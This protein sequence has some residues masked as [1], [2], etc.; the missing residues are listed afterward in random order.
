MCGIAGSL[1]RRGPASD[2]T[3]RRQLEVL[4]HRGP[5][6]LGCW[7]DGPASIGQTRLAVIDL[8][9]GDP[10]ITT[11]S[12]D[13]AV[14]L[15]GEIYN[16]REIRKELRARGHELRTSGDTEVIAHLAEELEPV[17]LAQRL[18]GMF[19]F[20][21]WDRNRRRLL[22][23]RDRLGK[24][25]LYLYRS[26]S[27][28]VFGSEIKALLAHPLVSAELDERAIPG[29]LS[30]GYVPTP[31][32]FYRG[33][34]SVPPGHVLAI[35]KD[36]RITEH[37]YWSPAV[38]RPGGV[39]PVI[40]SA[41]KAAKEVRRLL[42]ASVERRLVAD[43][44]IGAFLSGGID[45]SAVVGIMSELGTQPVRT[46]TIGF[47]DKAGYDERPY[48]AMV[49]K[50]FGTDHTELV[51]DPNVVDLVE[52]L[53]WHHD[54]PFGDSSSIPTYLLAEL[55]R[56]QVTVSL[57]GDGGDELFAGYERFAA[58]LAAARLRAVPPPLLAAGAR[59]ARAVGRRTGSFRVNR[60]RRFLDFAEQG[61]PGAYRAWVNVVPDTVLDDLLPKADRWADDDWMAIWDSTLG[62]HDLDRL[63]EVNLRTYLLD[64]LLPKV[65]RMSMAHGLEVRTP[66]LDPELVEYALRLPPASKV[67]GFSLKRILK[68]SVVDL[69]PPEI[70][71]RPKRG[72][73]VPVDRWF[74]EDLATYVHGMLGTADAKVRDYLRGDAVDRLLA[75]HRS[76]AAQHGASL[77]SLLML[78][79]FLRR[80]G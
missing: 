4:V 45:S 77:W 8:T 34:E 73:A 59:A 32:T 72:F 12:G 6:A 30:Y 39:S 21:V 44:P 49:A 55:T 69:L 56:R 57:C 52:R 27:A 74:R 76:G 80:V 31:R 67:R 70:I 3:T 68:E 60:V 7:V 17:E 18:D 1:L 71:E 46:F 28:V 48:A 50:H 16:Y 79:A 51:V 20:A 38:P 65:D 42:T 29:F 41:E 40:L 5:D 47:D 9:T 75:E 61:L 64:D 66:F 11:P 62:A 10:P 23:G 53:T 37:R 24:K 13:I 22:L 78:E 54:Q 15:N 36:L 43:V 19:A 25:P 35:G 2:I 58:G 14:A 33:I 26:P 63:L